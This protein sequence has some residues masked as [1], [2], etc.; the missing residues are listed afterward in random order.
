[1]MDPDFRCATKSDCSQSCCHVRCPICRYEFLYRVIVLMGDEEHECKANYF[2][3]CFKIIGPIKYYVKIAG[4]K[5]TVDF[6]VVRCHNCLTVHESRKLIDVRCEVC[7]TDF[8]WALP[9]PCGY[10]R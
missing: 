7:D 9:N 8:R 6:L 1:M 10:L 3:D 4:H 2:A 5:R